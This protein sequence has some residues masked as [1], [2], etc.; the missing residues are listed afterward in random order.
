[1]PQLINSV[2]VWDIEGVLTLV[3][4]LSH[5]SWHMSTNLSNTAREFRDEQEG[6]TN[7]SQR[8]IDP[9]T[10]AGSASRDGRVKHRAA[11]AGCRASRTILRGLVMVPRTQREHP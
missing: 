1:M 6:R 11:P 3:C 7:D 5:S 10:L 2:T 8:H 9:F 4:I